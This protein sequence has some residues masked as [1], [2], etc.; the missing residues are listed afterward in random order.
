MKK[1]LIVFLVF[2][3]LL[4]ACAA[5]EEKEFSFR[6]KFR[7]GMSPDEVTDAEESISHRYPDS[8][9][10]TRIYYLSMPYCGLEGN[11]FYQFVDGKLQAIIFGIVEGSEEKTAHFLG[12][13]ESWYGT[14][15][16]PEEDALTSALEKTTG[17]TYSKTDIH[18]FTCGGT[19]IWLFSESTSGNLFLLFASPD[20]LSE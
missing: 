4:T 20:Y 3:L 7:W 19:N 8:S 5:A 1:I 2:V 13:L 6:G 9:V 17:G 11:L 10:P 14:E 16:T 12:I 15:E 18:R